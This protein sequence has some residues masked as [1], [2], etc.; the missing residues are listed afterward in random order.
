MAGRDLASG[1][2]FRIDDIYPNYEEAMMRMVMMVTRMMMM[3]M[4]AAKKCQT[5]P[6][7]KRREDKNLTKSPKSTKVDT[8]LL[9]FKK[10]EQVTIYSTERKKMTCSSTFANV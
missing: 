6:I 4:R 9:D 7:K 3:M 2:I 8:L 5:E 10:L 1:P